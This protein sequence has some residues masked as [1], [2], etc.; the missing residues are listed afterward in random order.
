MSRLIKLVSSGLI[1]GGL[2]VIAF[3]QQPYDRQQR[4]VGLYRAAKNSARAVKVLYGIRSDLN[5][6]LSVEVSSEGY[7]KAL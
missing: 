4:I 3:N 5:E 7:E 1:L 6:L 2:G